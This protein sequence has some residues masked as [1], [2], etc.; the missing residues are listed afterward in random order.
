MGVP[1]NKRTL[2]DDLAKRPQLPPL[3]ARPMNTRSAAAASSYSSSPEEDEND[4]QQTAT[5]AKPPVE[6]LLLNHIRFARAFK[7][8]DVAK[9]MPF[10]DPDVTLQTMDQGLLDG[11]SAVLAYLVGPRMTKLSSHIHLKGCPARSGK[12]QSRFVYEHGVLFRQPLYTEIVEWKTE[13]TIG[14]IVHLIVP[15]VK[16]TKLVQEL[17]AATDHA[18][19]Q[20]STAEDQYHTSSSSLQDDEEEDEDDEEEDNNSIRNRF[21]RSPSR[22][23]FSRGRSLTRESLSQ[24]DAPRR[25]ESGGRLSITRSGSSSSHLSTSSNGDDTPPCATNNTEFINRDSMDCDAS[26][27][28]TS[29]QVITPLTPIRKRKSVNPFIVVRKTTARG[30][31]ARSWKSA[32]LKKDTRPKWSAID[33]EFGASLHARNDILEIVLFDDTLFRATKVAGLALVMSDI[34][35]NESQVRAK[36]ELQRIENP[37]GAPITLELVFQQSVSLPCLRS[38]FMAATVAPTGGE[39]DVAAAAKSAASSES[40]RDRALDYCNGSLL[41]VCAMLVL[42]V[43]WFL[44]NGSP[45]LITIDPHH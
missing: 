23:S 6:Q 20:Y 24:Q 9:I 34:L 3:S 45:L 18:S 13:S 37:S 35:R 10:L 1:G 8:N 42:L 4:N 21:R 25:S 12:W 19:N 22:S 15:D 14:A 16:S 39:E 36:V 31:T 11:A 29:I 5:S 40:L 7:Q 43:V 41:L 44:S 32:V 30:V 26:L 33:L 17:L 27:V 38:S 2:N 28:L